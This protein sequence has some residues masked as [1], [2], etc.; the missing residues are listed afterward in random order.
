MT[1]TTSMNAS[2]RVPKTRPA[3]PRRSM[4][5]AGIPVP[6][7]QK[8][9]L[10][11]G[12]IF[13]LFVPFIVESFQIYQFTLAYIYAIA[14]VGLNILTGYNGQFSLGHSTFFAIG[15]YSTAIMMDQWDMSYY[16]TI[17]PAAIITFIFGFL[18]GLP[19]LRLDGLYLALATFALA[20]ATPQLLKYEPFAEYT[21]GVQGLDAFKPDPPAWSGLDSDQWLYFVVFVVMLIMFFLAWN[22]IHSRTGRALISIRDNPLSAK[23]MGVN[24]AMFKSGAFGVSAMF[25]GVAGSLSAVTVEFVAPESFLFTLAVLLLVGSVIGGVASIFGA[26]F[27]GFFILLIPNFSESLARSL[28]GIVNSPEGL[29]WAVY[30]IF[31]ILAV[32]LM[33]GGVAHLCQ[34]LIR[35][36][37]KPKN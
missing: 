2:Q 12:F 37:S 25:T 22:L 11:I 32:Y 28:D 34:L 31:L 27:G 24:S 29:S 26:I 4:A 9:L 20:I 3:D 5:I 1:D 33:P 19:A 36:I 18:F 6:A 35:K 21:G 7:M 30:G 15:A 10:I 16:S 8:G 14:I 17:I 13:A 23:T